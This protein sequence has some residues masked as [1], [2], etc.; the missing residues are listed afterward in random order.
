MT[1][2]IE[3]IWFTGMLTPDQS[4]FVIHYVDSETQKVRSYYLDFLI[5]K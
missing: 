4:D 2:G 5:R 1:R 3:N